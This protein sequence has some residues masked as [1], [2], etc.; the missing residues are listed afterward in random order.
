MQLKQYQTDTLSILRR[1]FEE[2]RIAGP[3]AAYQVIVSE[4]DQAARLGRY[5]GAYSPLKELPETPYVCLR[6]PTG[7]RQDLAG[8]PRRRRGPRRLD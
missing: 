8:G 2:A 5:A 1:F 4:P 7:G 6:L 3:K